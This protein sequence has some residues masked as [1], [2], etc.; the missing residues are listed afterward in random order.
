MNFVREGDSG[1]FFL[2]MKA[3]S[4]RIPHFPRPYFMNGDK[5]KCQKSTVLRFSC[6]MNGVLRTLRGRKLQRGAL[7]MLDDSGNPIIS[8]NCR[9]RTMRLLNSRHP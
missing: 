1:P 4:I 8:S 6:A 9:S 5:V 2:C 7:V 3:G